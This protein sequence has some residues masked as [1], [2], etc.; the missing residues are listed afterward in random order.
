M[1]GDG[2]PVALVS[3]GLDPPP[4][5]GIKKCVQELAPLMLGRGASIV[6]VRPSAGFLTRKLLS[7]PHL[8]RRLRGH[9]VRT[10]IYVPTQSAT[11]ASVVRAGFLRTLGGARVVLVSLQPRDFSPLKG[12]LARRIGPDLILT[13]SPSLI[14]NAR[15]HGLDA[16]FLALG[17]DLEAFAPVTPAQKESLRREYGLP[18]DRR[19][20]LHV[21]HARPGRGLDWLAGL[22][23]SAEVLP[24]VVIGRSLG[25]DDRVLRDL[26]AAGVHVVDRYL[27]AVHHLYQLADV[28]AFPVLDEGSAIALPLSVLEAMAC[29]LPVVTTRFGGLPSMVDP[30]AGLYFVADPAD[31]RRRVLDALRMPAEEIATRE[32]VRRYTWG[33]TAE[34]LMDGATESWPAT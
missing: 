8:M 5:E 31:F 9:G 1:R 4:D 34:A 3:D 16:R 13:P 11:A 26:R 10:V 19:I 27:P 7:S 21:G 6:P 20:V 28:Y 18:L 30:G 25:A 15:E 24:V 14:E 2:S 23:D 22:A 12:A 33:A 17:T 29:N 32:K